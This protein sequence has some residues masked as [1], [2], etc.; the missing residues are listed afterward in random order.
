MLML[1]HHY[2]RLGP[3]RG[4]VKTGA[5][6]TDLR[7]YEGPGRAKCKYR[8]SLHCLAEVL[9][10]LAGKDLLSKFRAIYQSVVSP[11]NP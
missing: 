2:R 7:Q 9:N 6:A 10:C 11:G 1:L 3:K 4:E 8:I 5:L